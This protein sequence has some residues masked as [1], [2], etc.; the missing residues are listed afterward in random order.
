MAARVTVRVTPRAGRE[1]LERTP[2]GELKALVAAPAEGGKAN[3]AVCR[4]VAE[5]LGVPKSRV[6]V[7]RGATA[8]IKVLEIDGA[9]GED[10]RRLR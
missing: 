2:T 4:L 7:V 5:A 1:G 8:R 9:T 3:A 6:R 10:L